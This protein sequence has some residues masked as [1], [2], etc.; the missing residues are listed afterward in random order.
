MYNKTLYVVCQA[1]TVPEHIRI[2]V[3]TSKNLEIYTRFVVQGEFGKGINI[4][5]FD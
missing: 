1:S 5:Y 4:H 3:S 2:Y